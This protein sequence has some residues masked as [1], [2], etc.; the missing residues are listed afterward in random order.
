MH[1]YRVDRHTNYRFNGEGTQERVDE[2]R[3]NG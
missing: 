3:I 1:R 2:K